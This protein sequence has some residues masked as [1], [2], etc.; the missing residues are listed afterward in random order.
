MKAQIQLHQVRF[1]SLIFRV[2]NYDE[3]PNPSETESKYEMSISQRFNLKECPRQFGIKMVLK[4]DSGDGLNLEVETT[5][6]FSTDADISEDFIRGSFPK[7]NAPAIVYPFVRAYIS[8]ITLN[9]G[10]R[11]LI[12]PAI[13]F[14]KL[15]N[16]QKNIK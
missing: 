9:G 4:I 11:P 3:S 1:P 16:E 14:E 5:A 2:D 12:L 8:T 7:I 10:Y 13:N 6:E 15:H